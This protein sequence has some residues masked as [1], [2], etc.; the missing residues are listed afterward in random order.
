MK[1]IRPM[2]ILFL[3]LAICFSGTE[4]F[5][6][7]SWEK[8]LKEPT[9]EN[10]GKIKKV[11]YS[12]ADERENNLLRDLYLLEIQV[13]SSDREAGRLAFR[14]ISEAEGHYGE[15]LC[16]MLGRLIRIDPKLFLEEL[17]NH[18]NLI[19]SLGHLVGNFGPEYVD[20]LEAGLYEARMRIVALKKINDPPLLRIR[21][22][23]IAILIED[24]SN[25]NRIIKELK[26]K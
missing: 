9:P 15:M 21:D 8:Y 17:K 19:L 20:R 23:C 5:A 10:A 11:E 13:I 14:L 2:I 24:I 6:Q 26:V 18:R 1:M 25:T 4:S 16:I 12:S 7:T 22:E 3:I